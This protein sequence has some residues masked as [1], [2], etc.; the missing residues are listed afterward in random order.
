LF[1]NIKR[2]TRSSK[3]KLQNTVNKNDKDETGNVLLNLICFTR[4]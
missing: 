4:L 1:T 3:R 2:P